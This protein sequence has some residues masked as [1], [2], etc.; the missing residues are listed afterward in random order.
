MRSPT[1]P[2]RW[3]C[4]TP[5]SGS[6]SPTRSPTGDR[7]V[8]GDTVAR[9]PSTTSAPRGSPPRT[10]RPGSVTT[11]RSGCTCTTA[12]ST[13]RP[14]TARSRSAACRSTSTTATST[15]SCGTCSTTPTPR[16]WCS[17]RRSAIGSRSVV[18]RL[19]KLKLL[20]EVDDGGTGQVDR[21]RALRRGARRPRADGAHRAQRG[22]HLHAVH[23]RHHRHAEGRDVRHRRPHVGCSSV[24]GYPVAR[25]GARPRIRRRSPRW[26][27]RS[28]TPATG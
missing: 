2:G 9:G 20:I 6:R 3:R 13:S 10:P 16:R 19:P 7:V 15:T 8:H 12:T 18:D 17:T 14:S 22:R 4:T 24:S 23:R 21:R 27:G 1:L 5:R 25:A 26:C 28:P 11:P